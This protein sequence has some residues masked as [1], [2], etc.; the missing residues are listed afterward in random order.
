MPGVEPP[1]DWVQKLGFALEFDPGTSTQRFNLENIYRF[2]PHQAVYIVCFFT[3]EDNAIGAAGPIQ[4][5]KK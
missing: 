4:I 1:P 2:D 5:K 3:D